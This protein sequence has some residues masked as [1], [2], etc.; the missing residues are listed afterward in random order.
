MTPGARHFS[1]SNE[2]RRQA[3]ESGFPFV[4][5]DLQV[6]VD[7]IVVR[8]RETA[9]PVVDPE[10][11]LLRASAVVPDDPQALTRRE[12]AE[13]VGYTR[14]AQLRGSARRVGSIAFE[15]TYL[16]DPLAVLERDLAE[17]PGEVAVVAEGDPLVDDERAVP[18][19]LDE[20][21]RTRQ[22][23]GLRLRIPRLP[24]RG[25]NGEDQSR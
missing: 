10:R 3:P 4:A 9:Q 1:G 15:D 21:V 18:L 6:E 22:R 14:R 19:D 23:E 5:P 13:G 2:A 17:R 25:E 11:S 7:D 24:E 20:D 12:R 16:V 8:R